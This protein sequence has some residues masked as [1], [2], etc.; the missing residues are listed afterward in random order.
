MC[1]LKWS[2]AILHTFVSR[3][4]FAH[5][6]PCADLQYLFGCAV[7][8]MHRLPDA[9]RPAVYGTAAECEEEARGWFLSAASRGHPGACDALATYLLR[10]LDAIK[11]PLAL[12]RS[13][14]DAAFFLWKG[15]QPSSSCG[16][17]HLM[18]ASEKDA[19]GR[20][21]CAEHL[22]R[23]SG[24]Q[25]AATFKCLVTKD[26]PPGCPPLPADVVDSM[27]QMLHMG[28]VRLRTAAAEPYNDFR[29][30]YLVAMQF[31][32]TLIPFIVAY[33]SLQH[34]EES[35]LQEVWCYLLSP[36]PSPADFKP[37][38][39]R[40]LLERSA[41]AG[42]APAAA[43]LAAVA[44]GGSGSTSSSGE[45][46]WSAERARGLLGGPQLLPPEHHYKFEN[47]AGSGLQTPYTFS[48]SADLLERV[49]PAG[50]NTEWEVISA[51][52]KKV[53]AV[54][55]RS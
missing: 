37:D 14:S 11:A 40:G 26:I 51:E 53:R 32:G 42:F 36:A 52:L 47:A 15:A 55:R 39:A 21:L 18:G 25:N 7:Q 13:Y 6:P 19:S 2:A 35:W 54:S 34:N 31:L 10:W 38:V 48:I 41:A 17:S 33:V 30:Q 27:A 12:P 28:P 1:K 50:A 5:L 43:F 8:R 4:M 49:P 24:G 20:E 45:P 44:A 22:R 29:A 23:L 3:C 46:D 16:L 9:S